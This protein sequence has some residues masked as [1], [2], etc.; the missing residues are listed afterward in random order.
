MTDQQPYSN[1]DFV[2]TVFWKKTFR[3]HPP[4][5]KR[6]KDVESL[7]GLVPFRYFLRS[8]QQAIADPI[9]GSTDAKDPFEHMPATQPNRPCEGRLS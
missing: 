5:L 3:F 1:G 6:S 4:L 7:G 2:D 9:P 8:T